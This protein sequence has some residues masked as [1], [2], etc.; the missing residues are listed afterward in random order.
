[1]D[2]T[3]TD[4]EELAARWLAAERRSTWNPGDQQAEAARLTSERYEEAVRL[5]TREELRLAWEAAKRTQ[6]D[7]LMGSRDWA[8]ARSVAE[9]LRME[10]LAVAEAGPKET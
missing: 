1:M 8:E 7:C 4:I 9:L 10:Y 3:E 5:A 2:P 6:A